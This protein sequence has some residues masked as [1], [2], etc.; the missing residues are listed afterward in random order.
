[1]DG[2]RKRFGHG[3]TVAV[4]IKDCA[5]VFEADESRVEKFPATRGGGH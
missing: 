3:T 4:E 2:D 5:E 1:M